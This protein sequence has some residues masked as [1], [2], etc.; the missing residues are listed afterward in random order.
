LQINR[1]IF[2]HAGTSQERALVLED[3][4]FQV[5][6]TPS[7]KVKSTTIT[8]RLRILTYRVLTRF[9]E[10]QRRCTVA[11]RPTGL[12]NSRQVGIPTCQAETFPKST[13]DLH[14]TPRWHIHITVDNG[15]RRHRTYV[16]FTASASC[17]RPHK[18]G[19]LS[20]AAVPGVE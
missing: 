9:G 2:L 13:F 20:L 1:L 5:E 10:K 4:F 12:H 14:P 15:V 18:A 3:D 7:K 16:Q 6:A 11:L 8:I 17:G 19:S